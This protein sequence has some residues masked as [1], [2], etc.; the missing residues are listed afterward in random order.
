MAIPLNP[1]NVLA[2]WLGVVFVNVLIPQGNMLWWI[3]LAFIL[4]A[5]VILAG[6]ELEV[7]TDIWHIFF[8]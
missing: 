4:I 2:D 6:I 8:K 3:G 5:K 7:L 1:T